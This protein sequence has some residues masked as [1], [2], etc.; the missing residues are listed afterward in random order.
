MSQQ[1]SELHIAPPPPPPPVEVAAPPQVEKE[2]SKLATPSLLDQKAPD[3]FKRVSALRQRAVVEFELESSDMALFAREWGVMNMFAMLNKVKVILAKL[4]EYGLFKPAPTP[5][6]D[7]DVEQRIEFLKAVAEERNSSFME[8]V[9]SVLTDSQDTL[10]EIME[11]SLHKD[12][13]CKTR[14][15]RDFIAEMSVGDFVLAL[16][17]IWHSNWDLGTLKKAMAPLL[18]NQ[19]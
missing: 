12:P 18:K 2:A 9:L 8:G 17:A 11:S 13:E 7:F 6:E 15:N 3:S 5:P 14:L 1:P 4:K 19:D 16:R 10:L